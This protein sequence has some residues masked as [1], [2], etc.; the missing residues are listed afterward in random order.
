[1]KD[2]FGHLFLSCW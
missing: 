2:I 1:L